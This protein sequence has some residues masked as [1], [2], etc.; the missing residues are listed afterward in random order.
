MALM[1]LKRL[2]RDGG[3]QLMLTCQKALWIMLHEMCCA[4]K[5]VLLCFVACWLHTQGGGVLNSTVPADRAEYL[6]KPKTE[7]L[8]LLTFCFWFYEACTTEVRL[9]II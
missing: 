8:G 5:V 1:K 9:V 2:F 4:N 7:T 3:G 6:S